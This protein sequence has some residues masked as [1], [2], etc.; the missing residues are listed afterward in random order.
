[1]TVD[2]GEQQANGLKNANLSTEMAL[3]GSCQWGLSID[4]ELWIRLWFIAFRKMHIFM[5]RWLC[6]VAGPARG[7]STSRAGSLLAVYYTTSMYRNRPIQ[8]I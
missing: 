3:Q 7:T 4:H 5:V 6:A 2:R 1:M 8:I